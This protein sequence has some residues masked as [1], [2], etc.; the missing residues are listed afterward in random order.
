MAAYAVALQDIFEEG[1]GKLL[2]GGESNIVIFNT[3]GTVFSNDGLGNAPVSDEVVNR[4]ITPQKPQQKK[5]GYA[6]W[7]AMLSCKDSA[8]CNVV[9]NTSNGVNH[10]GRRRKNKT[11]TIGGEWVFTHKTTTMQ[12]GPK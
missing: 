4:M 9:A 8:S 12:Q 1:V 3:D 11:K 2:D 5:W 6:K 10:G 7:F